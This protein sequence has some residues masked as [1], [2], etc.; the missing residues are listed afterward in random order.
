MKT[1]TGKYYQCVFCGRKMFGAGA[2]SYHE[3]WCRENP[4]NK[5][6]CFAFCKHLKRSEK[7]VWSDWHEE[8]IFKTEFTCKITKQKMYSYKREKMYSQ[9][10]TPD[11]IRMPLTCEHF[12]TDRKYDEKFIEWFKTFPG[13]D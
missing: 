4:K 1:I 2:M 8:E 7:Y 13:H 6:I 12:S 3:K 5:H 10:I 9:Y 11:M